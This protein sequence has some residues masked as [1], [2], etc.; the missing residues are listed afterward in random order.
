[1]K[2][3]RGSIAIPHALLTF[4]LPYLSL[5]ARLHRVAMLHAMLTRTG[6]RARSAPSPIPLA[7]VGLPQRPV[8]FRP[9]GFRLYAWI[10]GCN[11]DECDEEDLRKFESLGEFFY[12]ELKPGLRPIADAPMVRGL[13]EVFHTCAVLTL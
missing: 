11:L 4:H 5:V 9:T 7:A 8:W 2:R 6:P 10:F 1:M 12:R 13:C 3:T